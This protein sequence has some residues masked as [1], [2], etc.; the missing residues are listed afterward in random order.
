MPASSDDMV[1]EQWYVLNLNPVPWTAPNVSIGRK[2]G[3]VFPQF[4]A[5]A[6]LKAFKEAV[7][8][9]LANLDNFVMP[10][11]ELEF[12][13]W[14]RMEPYTTDQQKRARKHEAD[15]TNLQKAL[16][17]ALQGS[18]IGNDRDVKRITSWLVEQ[19]H[20]TIPRIIIFLRPAPVEPPVIPQPVIDF[21]ETTFPAVVVTPL[22][23][24]RDD[25]IED[26]F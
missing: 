10:P 12:Y 1:Q 5:S 22:P 17:D 7:R 9:Q 13:F 16:E 25:D 19:D 21:I 26:I 14:R 20:D 3:K 2:G 8:E 18:I 24:A 15:V 11:Y 4:Y 23:P 6:E